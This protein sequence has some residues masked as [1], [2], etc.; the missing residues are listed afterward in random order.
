MVDFLKK[1]NLHVRDTN[2]VFF[3]I[4]H[5]YMIL[6]DPDSVYTSVTRLIH[7]LFPKFDADNVI[8]KIKN[9]KNWNETNKYWGKTDKE[10]KN[11]WSN[12]GKES[13]RL[14][15]LLHENIEKFMNFGTNDSSQISILK[16]NK[17]KNND[18]D[19]SPEWDMFKKFVK[20]YHNLIPYR[21]EWLIYDEKLKLAGS[22]DMV[23]KNDDG[24]VSI[25]DWKRCKEIKYDT[26]WNEMASKKCIKH[27]PNT[28]YWHYSLQLNIYR[29]LLERNYGLKVKELFLIQLHRE[30]NENS[31]EK[32]EVIIFDKEI[33]ELFEEIE[34]RFKV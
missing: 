19:P 23:Y 25:Y 11:D 29:K 16:S 32:H 20:D 33:E 18:N 22:I 21:T 14:G 9:G 2:I 34:M 24:S 12:N 15:T 30:N 17:Y 10:I 28:N 1:Q 5:K 7:S 31:Y 13:A 8:S 27:L 4:G 6:T 26:E 3:E